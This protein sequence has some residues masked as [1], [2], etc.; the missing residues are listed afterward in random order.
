MKTIEELAA[1]GDGVP[2]PMSIEKRANGW[3][4]VPDPTSIDGP[5]ASSC[6]RRT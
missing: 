5:A 1:S 2:V 6:T 3:G 4:E